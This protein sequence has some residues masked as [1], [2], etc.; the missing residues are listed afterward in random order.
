MLPLLPWPV[1]CK[2]PKTNKLSVLLGQDWAVSRGDCWF[3]CHET[4]IVLSQ[5]GIFAVHGKNCLSFGLF[6]VDQQSHKGISA[7]MTM[8]AMPAVSIIDSILQ[9]WVTILR[10]AEWLR[11]DSADGD[12]AHLAFQSNMLCS[13]SRKTFPTL[14][15]AWVARRSNSSP[16]ALSV[17]Q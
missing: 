2:T 13:I 5:R 3:Y 8:T 9:S 4:Q 11:Q 14:S 15:S 6:Q 12:L 1:P 16:F 7:K 10:P 17:I